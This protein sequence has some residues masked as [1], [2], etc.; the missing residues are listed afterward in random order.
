MSASL[1]CMRCKRSLPLAAFPRPRL[2]RPGVHDTCRVCAAGRTRVAALARTRF[3]HLWQL[4]PA[5]R[6]VL[7]LWESGR[8]AFTRALKPYGL[9]VTWA[10]FDPIVRVRPGSPAASPPSLPA[11]CAQT[12]LPAISFEVSPVAA[13]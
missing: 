10:G 13:P 3:P 8:L 2:A 11:V 6:D 7:V 12:P 1:D 4:T 5:V 9:E